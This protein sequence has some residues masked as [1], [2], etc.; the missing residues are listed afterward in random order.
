MSSNEVE[1]PEWIRPGAEVV[2][3]IS[4]NNNAWTDTIKSV[5]KVWI[6]LK[7]LDVRIR[8][9]KLKSAS[10]GESWKPWYYEVFE[11]NSPE[12]IRRL[13]AN[14]V[15]EC[16]ER[17]RVIYT[18]WDNDTRNQVKIAAVAKAM[19]DLNDAIEI[20]KGAS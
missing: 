15:R 1:R 5:G 20:M 17:A 13:N 7:E 14:Y 4:R 8:V 18:R 19:S 6:T 12:G 16:V 10:Q 2:V 3:G 9:E 11:R